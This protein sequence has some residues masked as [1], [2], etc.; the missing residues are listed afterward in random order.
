MLPDYE[1][2]GVFY[3]GRTKPEGANFLYDSSD[4]VT[5]AVCVGMTGSGKTG[6]CIGLLEE[7]AI[8][9]IPA[10]VID[11]K[12]DLGNL[13]LTFPDLRTED[14]TPWVNPDEAR[15]Q[16]LEPTAFA[17][18][19][20]GL[21]KKGLASWNEDGGRIARLQ[22]AADF[23]IYTPGSDAGVPVSILASFAV[24]DEA[25]LD[26][27]E[28]LNDRIGATVTSLLGLAGID[29]D[30]L[31]SRE[32]ILLSNLIETSWRGGK[33]LDLQSLISQ[34][35]MPTIQK[36]GALEI[37]TFYPAKDRFGLAMALNKLL[38][39]PGFAVWMSGEPLDI[40]RMLWTDSGKPRISIFSIAHL[41]DSERMFFVSLLLNQ[42]L[43][44]V[45]TQSGTTSLRALLYM[46]EIFGYFPPVA[47]PPS[48]KPLLTLLK[49]ARAF[50]L[51]VVLSTQNPVDL[52]YKGLANAGTWFLGRLQT[53]RDKQRVL[54]GLEGAS[55]QAGGVFDRAAMDKLL[56]GLGKRVFLMNNVHEK[57]P[58]LFETR[59]TLSYLRG[60][61]ARPE[62]KALTSA[63]KSGLPASS[64]PKPAVGNSAPVLPPEIPQYFIPV[65][66]SETTYSPRVIGSA[67]IQFLDDKKGVNETREVLFGTL[68][69]DDAV[70]AYWDNAEP[71]DLAASDLEKQ[72]EEGMSFAMLPVAAS[73]PKNYDKW[74][75]DFATWLFRNQCIELFSSPGLKEMSHAGESERDFRIRL[76]QT[77]R[78]HRDELKEKLRAKYEPKIDALAQR[79][80]KAEQRHAVE[81]EQSTAQMMNTAISLGTGLLGVLFGRG[82]AISTTNMGRV[83]TTARSASRAAK[84]YSDI[85]RAEES[86]AAIQ[87]QIDDLNAQFESEVEALDTKIDPTTEVF[88]P[89]TVRPKKTGITVRFVA[90]GWKA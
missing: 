1:K 89:V 79:K 44:W 14:F 46:D 51:G 43:S 88:E 66:G 86:V 71:L 90:L 31:R 84:E 70:G 49:Q 39:S 73:K 75:K 36:I 4:L 72:P 42:V 77:A 8:D 37:D 68:I 64:V 9:G 23:T 80:M 60:P 35:L 19:Q 67:Q 62:I 6:L 18:Q 63:R 50:G 82:K 74:N 12:G 40:G 17:A 87:K 55:A 13:L 24:P 57:Q 58:I 47:N 85:G 83:A 25:T 7:A 28:A 26:D 41:S 33:D 32:H 56:S 10:I 3:L 53:E 78:E 20:A 52:D 11:P 16:G 65:R 21:W 30:P 69:G 76:Q 22:K 54:E 45:R 27:R 81:K 38:A 59:W 48:K 34:I 2:L 61:L 15:T 29:A 5:H